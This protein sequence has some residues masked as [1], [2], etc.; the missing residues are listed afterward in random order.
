M[1]SYSRRAPQKDNLKAKNTMNYIN[2][3]DT[4]INTNI[5]DMNT[6]DTFNAFKFV[7]ISPRKKKIMPDNICSIRNAKGKS[8]LS[9]G[10][11]LS[12]KLTAQNIKG[13]GLAVNDLTGEVAIV[14]A[15]K[16]EKPFR[17]FYLKASGGHKG[18]E[19]KKTYRVDEKPF[20]E[21]VANALGIKD[22]R[23]HTIELG[24]NSAKRNNMRFHILTLLD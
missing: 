6:N 14:M 9:F 1:G 7:E 10:S 20:I 3:K 24:E 11:A 21:A 15:D 16:D 17:P 13:I 19:K 18:Y 4:N 2:S 8:S 5:N 22:D 12:E 23:R